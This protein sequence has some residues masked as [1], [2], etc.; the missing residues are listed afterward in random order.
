METIMT[1]GIKSELLI[2]NSDRRD[3]GLYTCLTSNSFGRDDTNI[4]L[5][6]QGLCATI[7]RLNLIKYIYISDL[8]YWIYIQSNEQSHR[9]R[10]LISKWMNAMDA[11]YDWFGRRRIA[12]IV[13]S[14]TTLSNTNLKTVSIDIYIDIPIYKRKIEQAKL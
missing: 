9:M 13:H 8:F 10:Q 7:I 11:H 14:R 5:I 6:V 1:E 2:R 3:G 12:E 4:Q